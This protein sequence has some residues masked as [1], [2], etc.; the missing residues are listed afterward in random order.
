[1][2]GLDLV[3]VAPAKSALILNCFQL[4]SVDLEGLLD[5]GGFEELPFDLL[6]AEYRTWELNCW[7]RSTFNAIMCSNH[8]DVSSI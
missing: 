3:G 6:E 2:P 8:H 5:E 7:N 1:M 4:F